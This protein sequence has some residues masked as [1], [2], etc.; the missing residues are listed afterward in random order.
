MA[1]SDTP[2]THDQ[3]R[4]NAASWMVLALGLLILALSLLQLLYRLALPAD[5]WSFARDATGAGQRLIFD[6]NLSDAPSP[7]EHNDLLVAIE[8]QPLD[9][10]LTGALIVNP[11]R[12]ANWAVGQGVHYTVLRSGRELIL[13]VLLGL[14]PLSTVLNNLGESY[15]KNP[16]ALF[17]LLIALFVFFRRNRSQP[18]RLLF[19]L[20]ACVFASDGISQAVNHSNVVDSAVLFDRV[21]YWPVQF[22][23]NLIWPLMIAPIYVHLFLIFPVV[24]RPMRRYRK[25]TL[26]TVFSFMPVLLSLASGISF[27]QPLVFWNLMSFFCAVD[28]IIVVLIVSL[29]MLNNLFTVR[30]APERA[31]TRWV[32]WGA[33]VTTMGGLV[34]LFL[35]IIGRLGENPLLDFV[36]YRLP[37]VAFPLALAIAI[38][39]YRL[40]DIDIIIRRTLIY[41]VLTASLAFV[42]FGSVVSLQQLLRALTGQQQSEIVTVTS[43]LGIA[44]LFVP[45]RRGVQ[46]II[47]RRFYRRKY[48]AAKVLAAFSATARDEVGLKTLTDSFL[49]VV[50]ETMQPAHVSLWLRNPDSE[51][52]R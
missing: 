48:D 4:F 27:G 37:M 10:I 34:G 39:H 35:G 15:L 7:L 14:F 8:G 19:L 23:N 50:E 32:A 3:S 16:S 47:D 51:V 40:F 20:G 38:L 12:P 24:R 1:T 13:D 5:G 44:A 49:A 33:L 41:S 25:R 42:Y 6:R 46:D 30:N 29:I 2:T 22:F 28:F 43:T 45:L 36:A 17:T 11:K 31:Q 26:A 18:A 9:N 52:K 21:A